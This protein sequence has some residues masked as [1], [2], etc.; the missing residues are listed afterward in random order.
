MPKGVSSRAFAVE[1]VSA[2][3]SLA[4]GFFSRAIL[5]FNST[6]GLTAKFSSMYSFTSRFVICSNLI[7]C[8]T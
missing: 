2:L 1:T 5:S 4:L 3:A 8:C 7:A 6:K